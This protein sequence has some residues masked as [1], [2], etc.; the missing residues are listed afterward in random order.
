MG[1][2]HVLAEPAHECHLVAVDGVDDT[3]GT[4]EEAGLEHGVGEQVEHSGH[5]SQL[6][7]VVEH[8]LVSRKADAEGHHHEGY[9]RDG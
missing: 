4:E 8:G 2:G 1:D 9:L 5:E 3:T 6:G 7:V